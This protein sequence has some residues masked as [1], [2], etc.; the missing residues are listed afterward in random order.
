MED[1]EFVASPDQEELEEITLSPEEEEELFAAPTKEELERYGVS[2]EQELSTKP[3]TQAISSPSAPTEPSSLQ[4]ASDFGSKLLQGATYGFSDEAIAAAKA[5]Y[6]KATGEKG[7]LAELYSKYKKIEEQKL[8]EAE[9]RSPWASAAGEILGGVLPAAASYLGTA[10]TGGAAAPAAAAT[11]ARTAG[12]L[13]RMASGAKAGAKFGALYG[14]GKSEG[15]VFEGAEGAKKIAEDVA[16]GAAGGAVFGGLAEGVIGAAGKVGQAAKESELGQKL[17]LV[18]ERAEAGLP[19]F[20]ENIAEKRAAALEPI[21]VVSDLTEKIDETAKILGNNIRNLRE[22]GVKQNKTIQPESGFGSFFNRWIS[23]ESRQEIKDTL[24]KINSFKEGIENI[25][26]NLVD[27]EGRV[28]SPNLSIQDVDFLKNLSTKLGGKKVYDAALGIEKIIPGDLSFAD[29]LR[30]RGLLKNTRQVPSIRDVSTLL[31]DQIESQMETQVPGLSEATKAY[32]KFLSSTIE[33]LGGKGLPEELRETFLDQATKRK[34][35]ISDVIR[36]AV[37]NLSSRGMTSTKV[38]PAFNQMEKEF[39][40]LATNPKT[41]GVY[42]LIKETG[43][44]F[45]KFSKDLDKASLSYSAMSDV[46][47][48]VSDSD[49]TI[50]GTSLY[51]MLSAPFKGLPRSTVYYLTDVGARNKAALKKYV[52]SSVSKS[53][54]VEIARAVYSAAPEQ[55]QQLAEKAGPVFADAM[56]KAIENKDQKRMNAL[57]FTLIQKPEVREKAA[58]ILTSFFGGKEKLK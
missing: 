24:P 18:A 39:A 54:P 23:D 10:V 44:D 27:K 47:K 3:P 22:S 17:A 48:K 13:S 16:G 35:Y 57:A 2:T 58:D 8:K 32:N 56:K 15:S 51:D 11:T 7:D 45:P 40:E 20:S 26:E 4:T 21:K 1:N 43:F 52:S 12:I 19:R 53:K 6:T 33:A 34:E 29:S 30:L 41:K 31:K 55:L 14:A 38:S 28:L 25:V 9:E 42:N 49:K 37:E 5:A 36:N 50:S 46:V